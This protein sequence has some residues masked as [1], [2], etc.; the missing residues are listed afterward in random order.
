MKTLRF[1]IST[2]GYTVILLMKDKK[3][4]KRLVGGYMYYKGHSFEVDCESNKLI[5]RLY[6]INEVE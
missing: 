5:A 4:G 2:N 1:L 3:Y 6:N